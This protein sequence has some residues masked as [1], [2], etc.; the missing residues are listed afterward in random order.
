MHSTLKPLY[1][2]FVVTR[3][4]MANDAAND[5]IDDDKSYYD[6]CIRCIAWCHGI[7]AKF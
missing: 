5:A 3:T 4:T 1:E 6:G 2:Y 7:Y